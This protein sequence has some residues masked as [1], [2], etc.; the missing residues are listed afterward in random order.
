MPARARRRGT[1]PRARLQRGHHAHDLS[2]G[3]TARSPP[4]KRFE[5][6]ARTVGAAPARVILPGRGVHACAAAEAGDHRLVHGEHRREHG[7]ASVGRRAPVDL[8][9]RTRVRC[10]R[11]MM[12][13]PPPAR[14]PT[15]GRRALSLAVPLSAVALTVGR[16]HW[17]SLLRLSESRR[18][19]QDTRAHNDADGEILLVSVCALRAVSGVLV[20]PL[21]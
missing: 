1:S 10:P 21:T 5:G 17:G 3:N 6:C 7:G 8:S 11:E 14:R 13:A 19:H 9:P 4:K 20:A 2:H 12:R 16:D 18:G 15:R